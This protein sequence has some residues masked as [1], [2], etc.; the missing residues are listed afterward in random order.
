MFYVYV[1]QSLS[2]PEKFYVGYTSDLKLR[3]HEHNA[4]TCRHTNR[5]KPWKIRAY[6]AFDSKDKAEAFEI[7]LKSHAGRDFQKK[8]L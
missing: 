3:L 1:L 7:Y 5:A 2:V 4:G 8:Y 6:F